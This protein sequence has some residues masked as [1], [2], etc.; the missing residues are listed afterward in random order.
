MVSFIMSEFESEAIFAH[1][2]IVSSKWYFHIPV[3][4]SIPFWRIIIKTHLVYTFRT[5]RILGHEAEEV[6]DSW[7]NS[8]MRSFVM[9]SP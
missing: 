9:Y 3:N 6:H 1:H 2:F 8:I 7:I 4:I 5:D